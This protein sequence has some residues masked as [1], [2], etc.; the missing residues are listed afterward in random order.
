LAS[1]YGSY[2]LMKHIRGLGRTLFSVGLVTLLAA[3]LIYTVFA[4]YSRA[5]GFQGEGWTLDGAA[6]FARHHPD[7]YAAVEWLNVHA[8]GAPVVL[9]TPGKSYNYEGRISALTGLPSVLGWALHE[10]QWRGSYEE[11]GRREADI[12][13]I[14]STIVHV[15]DDA[16][17][18]L[19]L[20]DKYGVTYVIVGPT[21]LA[22]YPQAGLAKFDWLLEPVFSQG[23]V[24]IYQVP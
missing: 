14:Y 1:A 7:D 15:D 10:D 23:A 21:E 20:L 5:E 22:R 24:T 12:E 19:A 13:A 8:E 9:E 16:E 2:S 3:G 11:Q 6:W 4:G 17:R 18:V